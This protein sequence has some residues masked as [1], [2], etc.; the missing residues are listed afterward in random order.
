M[1]LNS[2]PVTRPDYIAK[3]RFVRVAPL[4]ESHP[5]P[6]A[7]PSVATIRVLIAGDHPTLR[8]CLKTMLELDPQIS[9]VG[10]ASDDC[11]LVKMAYRVRPDVVLIDI[12]RRCCD[13]FDAVA[14]IT[15]GRLA[16]S[17][18][19]LTIHNDAEERAEAQQAGV[20]I[21]LEKGVPYK[22]LISAV[23]LA[24]ANSSKP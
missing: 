6:F 24:S 22:Q 11:E 10:E 2:R 18:V 14:E 8:S 23:R 20:N 9:V 15:Q 7:S 4:S 19:A 16:Q 13:S 3:R 17:V 21:F 12:D 5:S 1:T